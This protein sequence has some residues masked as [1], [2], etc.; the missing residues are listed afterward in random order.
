VLSL[1]YA[2]RLQA[3]RDFTIQPILSITSPLIFTKL[4]ALTTARVAKISA[5]PDCL[6]DD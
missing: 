5:V 2:E 6:I 3:A 1:L 4:V